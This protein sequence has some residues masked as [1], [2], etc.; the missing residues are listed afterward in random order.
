M[1]MQMWIWMVKRKC[2]DT[3]SDGFELEI[4]NDVDFGVSQCDQMIHSGA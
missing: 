3:F 2:I 4:S 1:W